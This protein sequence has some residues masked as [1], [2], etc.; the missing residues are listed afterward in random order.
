MQPITG[1][2]GSIEIKVAQAQA[3]LRAFA[4][5]A[6]AG[7]RHPDAGDVEALREAAE[8]CGQLRLE[9]PNKTMEQCAVRGM[10]VDCAE[11]IL[12]RSAECRCESVVVPREPTEAMCKA[13]AP[14]CRNNSF[15]AMMVY[16]AMLAASPTPPSIGVTLPTVDEM[17]RAMWAVDDPNSPYEA[18]YYHPMARAILQLI[19]RKTGRKG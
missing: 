19:E 13:G 14:H 4:I 5:L 15:T 10:A 3:A 8:I 12:A 18:H 9:Y 17:G 7:L 6:H 1:L 16:E 11:A 2:K